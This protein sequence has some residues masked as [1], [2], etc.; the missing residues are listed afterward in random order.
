MTVPG[1]GGQ[2]PPRPDQ[3]YQ[4]SGG[5]AVVSPGSSA[6]IVRAR[7]VIVSGTGEGV[8][9]YSGTPGPG[10]PP[11]LSMTNA[12]TDLFGNAVQPGLVAY[13]TAGAY[14]QLISGELNFVGTS[15]QFAASSVRTENIA[16]F[17]DLISGQASSLDAEAEVTLQSASASGVGKSQILLNAAQIGGVFSMP[18]NPP[19]G[20]AS[21]PSSYNQAWGQNITGVLN[22]IIA[23]IGSTGIW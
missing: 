19:S 23:T 17:L 9:V 6:G 13:G 5:Q 18:V 12:A 2:V 14:A 3:Q 15:G 1:L 22:N 4:G 7:I 16:G 10:N 8:F 20:P 21:A 11:I